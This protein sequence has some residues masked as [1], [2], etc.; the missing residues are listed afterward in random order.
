MRRYRG[1]PLSTHES[2][3]R[4]MIWDQK[5]FNRSQQELNENSFAMM[6]AMEARWAHEG[7]DDRRAFKQAEL[8]WELRNE[9][10]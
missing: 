4:G 9:E 5:N 10:D 3:A 7:D 1:N 6:G 2:E 8:A